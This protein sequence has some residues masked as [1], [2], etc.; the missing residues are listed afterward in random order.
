MKKPPKIIIDTNILIH[1]DKGDALSLLFRLFGNNVYI[2]DL[3]LDE[4]SKNRYTSKLYERLFNNDF[5]KTYNIPLDS[6]IY[7]EILNLAKNKKIGIGEASCL[8]VAKFDNSIIA[9]SDLKD[10]LEYCL[11]NNVKY[12]TTLDILS[13]AVN[14]KV[15][16]ITECNEIITKILSKNSY[17]TSNKVPIKK[18]EDY[19]PRPDLENYI[20]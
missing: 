11:V 20:L 6:K 13:I 16:S 7:S 3:V 17:L 19:K 8:V 1:L 9:S 5:F 14:R 2:L 18:I 4:L 10:I 12:I 15:I